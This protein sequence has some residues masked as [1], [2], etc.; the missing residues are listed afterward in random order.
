MVRV[1]KGNPPASFSL[2]L[3]SISG[4]PLAGSLAIAY[5]RPVA[6]ATAGPTTSF[7]FNRQPALVVS[8]PSGVGAS[9]V[10]LP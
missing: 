8:L 3:R 6:A 1:L 5:L 9:A 4:A 10:R 2:V 7:S